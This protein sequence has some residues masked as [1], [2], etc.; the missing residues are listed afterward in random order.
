VKARRPAGDHT[1]GHLI[2][3]TKTIFTTLRI[4]YTILQLGSSSGNPLPT[5]MAAGGHGTQHTD[6]K[7]AVEIKLRVRGA[8]VAHR[9]C[10]GA[11]GDDGDRPEWPGHV[12]AAVAV[13]RPELGTETSGAATRVRK[14][15]VPVVHE[16][17][18][19]EAI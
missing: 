19:G 8:S 13:L 18:E 3:L 16:V 11:L 1:V 5:T 9:G 15:L 6:A 17:R 10:R 4:Y 14:W 12:R 2:D 7:T